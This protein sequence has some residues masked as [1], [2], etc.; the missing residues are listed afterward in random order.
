M[1]REAARAEAEYQ[2]AP[3]KGSSFSEQEI[4]GRNS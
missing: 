3:Q 2:L 4:S 1:S